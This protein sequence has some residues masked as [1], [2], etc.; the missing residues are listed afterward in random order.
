L[1]QRVVAEA[2]GLTREQA[3]AALAASDGR[4]DDPAKRDPL[5]QAVWQRS[6][7]GEPA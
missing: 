7:P 4:V 5:D 2:A 3:L 1:P 6:E